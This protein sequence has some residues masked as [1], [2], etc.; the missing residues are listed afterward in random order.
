MLW[1]FIEKVPS[2]RIGTY[3]TYTFWYVIPT[4]PMFL[5]FAPLQSRYGFWVALAVSVILT[6]LCFLILSRVLQRFG[7]DLL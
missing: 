7:I 5:A 3:A 6:A 1:M 4:L 2:E